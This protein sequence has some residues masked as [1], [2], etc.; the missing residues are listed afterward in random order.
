VTDERLA[1]SNQ[2]ASINRIRVETA[3]SRFPIHRI[4]KKGTVS[5]DLQRISNT[6]EADFRWEVTYNTKHGQPGPL[7]Y[8]VDT[9]VVNRRIDEARRPIPEVIRLGSLSSICE[10][11]GLADSG[12]NIADV[13]RALHQNASAYI[14]AKLRY[15]LKSGRERWGE[16][17]YTRY[18]VIFTGEMLP[19]GQPADAVYILPNPSYRDLLNQVEVRPL[20]YDYLVE[21]APGPQRLYELLSFPMYGAMANGRSHAKLVYSEYCLYAPQTRYCIF[22]QVKKQMYKI[23]VPHRQ[24][25]YIARTEYRQ[26][27]DRQG[28]P[29]WEMLYMP[30]PRPFANTKCS[31]T[32]NSEGQNSNLFALRLPSLFATI[33]R[34]NRIWICP[35]QKTTGSWSWFVAV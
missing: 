30:G 14:T 24:S 23:H 16:I 6:G 1:P 17:G 10:E 26:I 11:L 28:N 21:L 27:T 22:D 20:D 12:G 13:K 8:K 33:I 25:G 34:Y 31:L 9:L 7:A 18:S 2:L 32:G 3:L 29:D 19:N 4:A 5:I 35:T 15:K